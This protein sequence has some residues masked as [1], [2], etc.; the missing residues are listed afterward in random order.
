MSLCVEDKSEVYRVEVFRL[1]SRFA[2]SHFPL[3]VSQVEQLIKLFKTSK[4][5]RQQKTHKN[6]SNVIMMTNSLAFALVKKLRH[7][8]E[9]KKRLQKINL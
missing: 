5:L 9:Q 3:N 4:C 2:S 6:V 8:T 7:K 1:V